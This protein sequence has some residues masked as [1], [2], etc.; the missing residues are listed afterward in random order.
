MATIATGGTW[1]DYWRHPD[2]SFSTST[3]VALPPRLDRL[4]RHQSGQQRL[5]LVQ[6]IA[7]PLGFALDMAISF[8]RVV[9]A[10]V[11]PASSL[12][13]VGGALRPCTRRTCSVLSRIA[14]F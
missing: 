12:A 10:E 1:G 4:E 7:S 8:H 2:R 14:D 5:W 13:R 9:V 3:C 11:G 6:G